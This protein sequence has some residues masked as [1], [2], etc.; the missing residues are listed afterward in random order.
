MHR[1]DQLVLGFALFCSMK[2]DCKENGFS[3]LIGKR[4]F[5]PLPVER[6]AMEKLN[7]GLNRKAGT[8]QTYQARLPTAT[9]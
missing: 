7:G 4:M 6:P 9:K 8:I 5:N 3:R 1:K 2:I